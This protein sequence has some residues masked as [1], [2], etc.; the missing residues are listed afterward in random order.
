MMFREFNRG[1]DTTEL[2]SLF[3]RVYPG[4]F[5]DRVAWSEWYHWIH[6]NNP[7][8][9]STIVIAEDNGRII[10]HYPLVYVKAENSRMQLLAAQN[11]DVMVDPEYRGKGIFSAIESICMKKAYDTGVDFIYGFPNEN[12]IRGHKKN[13][14]RWQ[15]T[16]KIAWAPIRIVAPSMSWISVVN[17][18]LGGVFTPSAGI[19]R[20]SKGNLPRCSIYKDYEK[21]FE[22]SL[23]REHLFHFKRSDDY[24]CQRAYNFSRFNYNALV[25]EN[26]EKI[27]GFFNIFNIG[28]LRICM[29]HDLIIPSDVSQL[30]SVK[31]VVN[32]LRREMKNRG[33]D[34]I[35]YPY[36]S[37]QKYSVA[38]SK[39]GLVGA[40]SP[41]HL[42]LYMHF[43]KP[44]QLSNDSFISLSDTDFS[45]YSYGAS[46]Y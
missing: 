20:N 25:S 18:L 37:G 22:N 19:E 13:G 7:I 33:V 44:T 26:E 5:R 3:E 2:H 15:C 38:L 36:H 30:E 24:L 32:A 41:L 21:E 43:N 42:Q 35:L 40:P 28:Y 11:I 23:N 46:F 45:G 31:K 10:G 27:I 6:F 29:I 9:E 4:R 14:W 16:M 1:D 12:A 17:I 8:R 39:C 34:A